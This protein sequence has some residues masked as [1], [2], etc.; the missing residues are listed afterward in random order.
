LC[1]RLLSTAA[2]LKNK[3]LSLAAWSEWCQDILSLFGTGTGK[4]FSG[5]DDP[6]GE[7][8]AVEVFEYRDKKGYFASKGFHYTKFITKFIVI[9]IFI[10]LCCK[11]HVA[12]AQ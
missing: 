3:Y 1:C 12:F 5:Q 7:S 10:D 9:L 8:P 6:N 11:V 2:G 4:G